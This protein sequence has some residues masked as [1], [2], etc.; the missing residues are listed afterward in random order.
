MD[1]VGIYR[2]EGQKTYYG[3]AKQGPRIT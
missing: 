2:E 3:K 1:L